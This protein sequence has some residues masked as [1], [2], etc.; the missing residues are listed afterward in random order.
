[1]NIRVLRFTT[2]FGALFF[3][4]SNVIAA[5]GIDFKFTSSLYSASSSGS[6]M[7]INLRAQKASD[8]DQHTA[9]IGFYHSQQ[10]FN[11]ARVGYEYLLHRELYRTTFSAQLASKGFLGGSIS[12]EFGPANL[13]GI[14]G[15]GRTNV[16]PYFNLN[17]DPNDMVQF[18]LGWRPEGLRG[19][20]GF[21]FYRVQDNRFHSGQAIT[22][23]VWKDV[24]SEGHRFSVD[25]FHK[26][27]DIDTGVTIHGKYGIGVAYDNGPWGVRLAYDPYVNFSSER[28][29]RL[30]STFRF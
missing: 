22:H 18:G 25:L 20:Q 13:Y 6:S 2:R 4:F 12:S 14:L 29:V 30:T 16:K 1:M 7:D 10:G 28:M 23:L 15:F 11:Q 3:L 24:Y 27:G 26:R 21:S 17:F 8:A 9:W 5:E 19:R